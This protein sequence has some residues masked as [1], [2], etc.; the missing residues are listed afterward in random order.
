MNTCRPQSCKA[1]ASTM[2]NV[3]CGFSS[4]NIHLGAR[5]FEAGAIMSH[6][7]AD[8]S[9]LSRSRRTPQYV[10]ADSLLT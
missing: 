10:A 7:L 3:G 9:S 4:K 8:C 5:R 6:T 1:R 2:A